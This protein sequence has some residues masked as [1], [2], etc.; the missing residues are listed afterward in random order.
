[1]QELSHNSKKFIIKL[2]I[3]LV[4]EILIRSLAKRLNDVVNGLP[5][6]F[7]DFAIVLWRAV[8]SVHIS[9]EVNE[10]MW[11]LVDKFQGFAVL[12][13]HFLLLLLLILIFLAVALFVILSPIHLEVR[14]LH[15]L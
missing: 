11:D 3:E 9:H 15:I 2:I 7:F 12:K 10:E 8:G 14:I 5:D 1:M 6:K 4:V 13:N